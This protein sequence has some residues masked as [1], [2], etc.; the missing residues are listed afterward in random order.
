MKGSMASPNTLAM[1][2]A[3]PKP[4]P[5]MYLEGNPNKRKDYDRRLKQVSSGNTRGKRRV[6]HEPIENQIKYIETPEQDQGITLD[7][8]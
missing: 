3:I 6:H 2:K 1:N 7:A 5:L 4:T 8:K